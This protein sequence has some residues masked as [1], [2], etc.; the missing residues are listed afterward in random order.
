ME[1]IHATKGN[2]QTNPPTI[3]RT[4]KQPGNRLSSEPFSLFPRFKKKYPTGI[5]MIAIIKPVKTSFPSGRPM[6][7]AS[8]SYPLPD[9]PAKRRRKL[10]PK[11]SNK[12]NSF[13]FIIMRL[14]YFHNEYFANSLTKIYTS[15]LSLI[16]SN[17]WQYSASESRSNQYSQGFPDAIVCALHHSLAALALMVAS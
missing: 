5:A 1:K 7:G 4:P 16:S 15:T 14:L 10:P 6:L 9:G 17:V 2:K 12:E 3:N 13:L 8:G 11:R